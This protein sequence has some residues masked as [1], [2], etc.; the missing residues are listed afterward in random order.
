MKDP[1]IF[2][3]SILLLL[4]CTE[5][6]NAQTGNSFVIVTFTSTYKESQHEQQT[7]HWI[8]SSDSLK[9]IVGGLSK[10]FLEPVPE[11]ILTDCRNKVSFDPRLVSAKAPYVVSESYIEEIAEGIRVIDR[12]KKLIQKITKR[13]P[14]GQKQRIWIYATPVEGV[15]CFSRYNVIGQ[16]R[17]GYRGNV[18]LPVSRFSYDRNFW[19]N[20]KSEALKTIDLIAFQFDLISN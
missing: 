13:W 20:S 16:E 6:S 10:L 1:R 17:N 9:Y 3:V 8:A 18:Y 4:S 5:F 15:F 7:Y 12:N 11:N 19:N 14:N 2:F